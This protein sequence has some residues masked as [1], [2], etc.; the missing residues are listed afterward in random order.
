[1]PGQTLEEIGLVEVDAKMVKL[2]LRLGPREGDGALEGRRHRD[3]CRPNR[4]LRR[5]RARPAS[6]RRSRAVAP[7]ASLMRRRRLKIGSST[8]PAVLESG[9]P[10]ITATG[11]RIPRPASQETR[12]IGL[13]LRAAHDLAFD[14]RDMRR[15][16]FA[17]AGEPRDAES[18]E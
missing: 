6:R 2:H 17:V 4:A 9:R 18:P 14:D 7:G 10:S 3:A 12:A 13:E 15:P 8:A 11:V 1:M 5:A 16:Q